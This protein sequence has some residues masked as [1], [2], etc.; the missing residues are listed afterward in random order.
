MTKVQIT[1]DIILQ[2]LRRL[3]G[4]NDI[5]ALE[6]TD[7]PKAWQGK[8]LQEILNV[9]Y[10]TFKRRAKSREQ[11][12]KLFEKAGQSQVFDELFAT[13]KGICLFTLANTEREFDKF[14]D[15]AV[16]EGVLDFWLQSSKVKVLELLIDRCM[17]SFNG[18]RIPVDFAG[19]QTR[20]V[21]VYLT[22]MTQAELRPESAIGD[23]LRVQVMVQ[24]NIEPLLVSR[25]DY[26]VEVAV[27]QSPINAMGFMPL[28]FA[29]ISVPRDMES[30]P[31]PK[32]NTIGKLGVI[33]LSMSGAV[34]LTFGGLADHPFI[35]WLAD[36]NLRGDINEELINGVWTARQNLPPIDVN[37]RLQVRITRRNRRYTYEMVITGQTADTSA[38]AGFEAH[39][40][41]LVPWGGI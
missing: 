12:K 8:T 26:T 3:I 15:T 4:E 22:N 5:T 20:H 32:V 9:E 31:L 35:E 16:C 38:D 18:V 36:Q 33:N 27:P 37:L 6:D 7:A 19:G 1:S 23:S 28:N 13:K 39:S 29:T 41:D 11:L 10:F 24:V 30:N 2:I 14:V 40:L 21:S 17:Q 25:Q 34:R